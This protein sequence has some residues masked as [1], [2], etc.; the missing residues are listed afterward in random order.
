MSSLACLLR[1]HSLSI[2][3]F[4]CVSVDSQIILFAF[5]IKLNFDLLSTFVILGPKMLQLH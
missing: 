5:L 1:S 2:I 3:V 4:S